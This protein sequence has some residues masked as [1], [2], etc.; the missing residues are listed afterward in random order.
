MATIFQKATKKQLKARI[1]LL[2][3]A[4]AGKS[5]SALRLAFALAGTDGKVAAIDTEHRSLSKY[6]GEAPDGTPWDFDVLELDSFSP[7]AYI[8]GITAAEQAGYAVLIIDS[9]SH[10]WAGKDGLLEFV[11]EVAKRKRAQGGA[12][13]TFD[14]W[15]EATPKH[16]AL[17]EAMLSSKMHL[18]VTMRVKQEYVQEK[19]ERTGKTIVRKVGLQPVQRDG[20]EYEMDVTADLD[21][22]NN[23]VIGK[24]RCSK[25]TGKVFAKAGPEVVKILQEWLSSGAPAT[26]PSPTDRGN[27]QHTEQPPA[28]WQDDPILV[29][30]FRAEVKKLGL[31]KDPARVLHALG[32]V[33]KAGDYPGS[34][35]EAIAALQEAVHQANEARI[36]E[37]VAAPVQP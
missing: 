13:N 16:N 14:A 9:L 5:Y 6:V 35:D 26:A 24:T 30:S 25:L 7:D 32:D 21:M 12:G 29:A 1:A 4:G 17:V 33:T 27:G 18:I 8:E 31:D 2:G 15:R 20:L 37:T 36:T 22:D 3:P 19:D 11:D 23:L 28:R 34:Y 10:A